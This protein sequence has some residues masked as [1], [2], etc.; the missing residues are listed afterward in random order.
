MPS[1][2]VSRATLL[3]HEIRKDRESHW[4]QYDPGARASSNR[5]RDR[6]PRFA[7][8]RGRGRVKDHCGTTVC[9]TQGVYA[10]LVQHA[11]RQVGSGRTREAGL[12]L[13][14][15]A[16]REH[17][18]ERLVGDGDNLAGEAPRDVQPLGGVRARDVR[19]LLGQAGG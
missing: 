1:S 9:V 12:A 16:A 7:R 13:K 6:D 18:P 3:S 17:L 5:V 2:I 10:E 4:T 8:R 15:S 19:N 11:G 14:Q